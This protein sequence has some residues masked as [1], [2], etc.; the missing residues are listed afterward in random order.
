[1]QVPPQGKRLKGGS[2]PFNRRFQRW[3]SFGGFVE[4]E[5]QVHPMKLFVLSAVLALPLTGCMKLVWA[6]RG[7]TVAEF[8]TDS[9]EC[10]RD[11]RQV[12]YRRGESRTAFFNRCMDARGWYMKEVPDD[13]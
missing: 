7:A 9:Y 1:V 10:E 3:R 4:A 13:D 5:A 11:S 6:K 8:K 12:T 2:R